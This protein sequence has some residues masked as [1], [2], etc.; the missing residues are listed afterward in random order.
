M[1]GTKYTFSIQECW[2]SQQLQGYGMVLSCLAAV[3]VSSQP[4]RQVSRIYGRPYMSWRYCSSFFLDFRYISLRHHRS[5]EKPVKN[6]D[7]HAPL[8]NECHDME[9]VGWIHCFQPA[10]C[11][12]VVNSRVEIIRAQSCLC[13]V[14]FMF[15][16]GALQSLNAPITEHV[17]FIT[18][19]FKTSISHLCLVSMS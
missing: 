5:C 12:L 4:W 10:S 18:T 19:L 2:T 9:E 15:A 1:N 3:E 14:L 11:S 6:D 7:S 16:W 13:V 17:C 8:Y